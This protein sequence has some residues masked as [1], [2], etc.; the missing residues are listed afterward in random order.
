M[1]NGIRVNNDDNDNQLDTK[2]LSFPASYSY[3]S[4]VSVPDAIP[5]TTDLVPIDNLWNRICILLKEFLEILIEL[6][7]KSLKMAISFTYSF[8]LAVIPLL[9]GR[10]PDPT[11]I[12]AIP[13]II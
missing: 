8:S 7:G 6:G 11:V 12:K 4:D 1:S 2:L 9:L 3:L 10:L 13:I 5:L